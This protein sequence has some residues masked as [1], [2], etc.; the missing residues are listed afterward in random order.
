MTKSNITE[1]DKV[2]A[3]NTDVQD[4]PLGENQMYPSD[5]NNAFREVMA[6]LAAVND[7]TV[8]LT[9]PSFAAAS[10]TGNLSFGDNDK[11]IF[12]AGSDL[13][14]YHDGS[15]SYITDAGQGDLRISGSSLV[16][17][18]CGDDVMFRATEGGST[19]LRY[20]GSQKIATTATGINVTGNITVSGTVDGRDVATDGTK[21]DGIEA[22]ATADQSASEIK[23][24]YESNANTNEFSDAE[25]SKLAGIETGATADQTAAE[26]LTAIKTV[27]GATSGL[28]ADLLD[29]NHASAFATAAQGALA[30]SALQSET[31]TSIALNTNSLDYTD[32]NGSVT[33][34]DLSVYLDEDARAIA[35][36]TLNSVTGIVTFTRDD[37]TTFT[38][39]LSDLLD[40]TNLVTSVA[41]KTGVVTLDAD[42]IDDTSTTNKFTTAAEITKLAGIEAGATADQTAAEI[43]TLVESATD[44]NVFTDADHS[45]LNGIEAGATADQTAA[46]ILT[47]IKTVDGSGSGLDADTVDGI[48]A[49]SFLRSD[50]NDTT[51]GNLTI[52]KNTATINFGSNSNSGPHGLQFYDTDNAIEWGMYYRTGP[53]TIT[54]E[55]DGTTA[56]LTLDTT[57]NLTAAG[58]VT[59]YSDERLKSNIK[60]LDGSK[61][62]EMRG[63]SYTKDGEASSGVIAQEIQKV[64]PELVN[65]SGEYLSVAY[66]N[67]VGYLIEA[68]KE[69]KAEVEALKSEK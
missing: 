54:F 17:I 63:V 13:Q 44:S 69:L 23:T 46:E 24:A 42:D 5:V 14:I 65:E 37:A 21:L 9:S 41:G 33:S 60:T 43:R 1:Y 19:Q 62:Y 38:L 4:V 12:G 67:L 27:D 39:D 61:V 25:Q 55:L 28:D 51:T 22:N 26:I 68:V 10:L 8:S 35:S 52:A 31:V 47:A 66:G 2:A 40:D 16:D 32:E 36:G 3:N 64:A 58:N 7:G 53:D 59:A 49:S 11:A 50:A 48:Q 18:K 30:D 34:I 57:G 15:H 29:G 6:D 45:K 56:K 20:D